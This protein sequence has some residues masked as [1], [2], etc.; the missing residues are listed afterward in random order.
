MS[1]RI[2]LVVVGGEGDP[3]WSRGAV[4]DV[5]GQ[6]PGG[7]AA[8]IRMEGADALLHWDLALGRPPEDVDELLEQPDDVWHAGLAL[9]TGGLPRAIDLVAPTWMLN[10][11]PPSTA[12]GTS[13]RVS[14]R[15]CL[16][17]ADVVEDLGH[18]DP[19]F[20]TVAGAALELGHRWITGGA[21]CRHVPGLLGDHGT[22]GPAPVIP[23]E[24]EVRFVRRRFGS[25][26]AAYASLRRR[27][28]A[29]AWR[30]RAEASARHPQHR[31]RQQPHRP[32]A[33]SV[34]VV[35]PTL[36]R[37]PWLE[38]LLAGLGRQ[39]VPPAEVVVADQTPATHRRPLPHV[40]GTTVRLVE[41]DE[42]GQCT[43]RNAALAV[44]S[45]D[46]VL[47]LDDDDEVPDDLVARHLDR[48]TTRSVT[49]SSGVA[50]EPGEDMAPDG[51]LRNSD[52][53]PTNNTMVRR[54]AVDAVG[55]FDPAYDHGDRA[56]HDLGMRLHLAGH[57]LLMDPQIG[58]LH[59][60]APSG[61][62]RT[63][64]A[65]TRTYAM[66]RRSL[67]VR[68]PLSPTQVLVWKRYYESHQVR[69]AV[70]LHVLGTFARKGGR[71]AKLGRGL[72]QLVL[73]PS[74]LRQVRR[75]V[76]DGGRLHDR[77]PWAHR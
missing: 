53:F 4:I 32:G 8:A 50:P 13:W 10:A 31:R 69:E 74:T 54:G 28:P 37:Y 47:F 39:T 34:S 52:V 18:L 71:S 27:A 75:A 6:A 38:V 2:D 44:A 29:A 42:P 21:L 12:D 30:Q 14:L 20:A 25:A 45:G 61:G 62:L 76:A 65:R 15:A 40:P 5:R 3:P 19:G 11:D 64:G 36:D 59:H 51:A 23:V 56:D 43:A 33:E 77:H 9:G 60:R 7:I 49:A 67:F 48:L 68:Q 17:R 24:D 16:V 46:L 58:V 55:A 73:L 70:R 41:L 72:I 63:H 26:W 66:S 1:R 22:G 57:R 35:V